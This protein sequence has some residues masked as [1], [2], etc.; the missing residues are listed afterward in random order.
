MDFF[1]WFWL[2]TTVILAFGISFFTIPAIIRI[3]NKKNFADQPDNKRKLHAM[4]IPTLGGI[5][6]FIAILIP[7][8]SSGYLAGLEYFGII[9]AA[10]LL[11]F[12]IGLFDDLIG[13][14]ALNKL[15]AQCTAAMLLVLGGKVL[16]ENLYGIFGIYILPFWLSALFGVVLILVI[17]NGYNFIDGSDGLAACIGITSSL[18]FGLIFFGSGFISEGVFAFVISA[19]L[20]GFFFYNKPPAKIFMGDTG[21]LITGFFLAILG[22][23]LLKYIP[24]LSF[25][26]ISANPVWLLAILIIP[27]YDTARII[28]IRLLEKSSPLKSDKRHI[29]H[30]LLEKGY[31]P[32]KVIVVL[33]GINVIIFALIVSLS[34]YLINTQLVIVA[35]ITSL[36]LLPVKT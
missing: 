14:S 36:I 31:S 30:K 23:W 12:T 34:P 16:V 2:S 29:H 26:G 28:T 35:I 21:S 4:N 6:V 25:W 33:V 22:I 10:S 11:L 24:D 7:Y 13:I 5:A 15:Y 18:L 27:F 32:R 20:F 1:D 17:M 3:A 8:L 19:S 9:I